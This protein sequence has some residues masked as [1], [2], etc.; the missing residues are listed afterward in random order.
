L[1]SFRADNVP[2]HELGLRLAR[3]H[4]IAVRVGLHCTPDAHRVAGT[5]DTGLVRASL[6]PNHSEADAQHFVTAVASCLAA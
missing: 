5:L 4:A 6:G 3:D 1:V 2:T